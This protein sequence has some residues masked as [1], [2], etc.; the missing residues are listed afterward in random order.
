MKILLLSLFSIASTL[1][2]SAQQEDV[3][4]YKQLKLNE[5]TIKKLT[6]TSVAKLSADKKTYT[7]NQKQLNKYMPDGKTKV[8]TYKI[9]FTKTGNRPY[10]ARTYTWKG[11]KR[12]SYIALK[13]V[14]NELVIYPT[15]FEYVP[16]CSFQPCE[17]CE[18]D[19]VGS[20]T[21]YCLCVS[22]GEDCASPD[23]SFPVKDVLETVLI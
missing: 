18:M 23:V 14:K 12:T 22:H 17:S 13:E 19:V 5:I 4:F 11:Y 20:G 3:K 7:I 2:A 15:N 16:D 21:V 9:H 8:L 1:M 6:T 10:L